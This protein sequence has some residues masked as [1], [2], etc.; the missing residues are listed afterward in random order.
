MKL[1]N[2]FLPSAFS[3]VRRGLLLRQGF[4][5]SGNQLQVHPPRNAAGQSDLHDAPVRHDPNE[6]LVRN[7]Q[8]FPVGH[9]E[10]E[11]LERLRS[12]QLHDVL[13]IH[14]PNLSQTPE[15]VNGFDPAQILA[16]DCIM[17]PLTKTV[18][19]RLGV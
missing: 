8:P 9:H 11:R 7:T 4:F 18:C 10:A 6:I 12:D 16:Y 14:G 1:K 3:F 19:R 5:Q 17:I 13:Y 15:A 2:D